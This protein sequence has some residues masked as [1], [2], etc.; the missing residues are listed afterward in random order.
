VVIAKSRIIPAEFPGTISR[1]E[2]F[3]LQI[4]GKFSK[5][6]GSIIPFKTKEK[7][8]ISRDKGTTSWADCVSGC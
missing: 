5:D 4:E 8:G 7:N 3:T 1:D 2:A 6:D